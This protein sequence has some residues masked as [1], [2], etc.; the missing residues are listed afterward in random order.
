MPLGATSGKVVGGGEEQGPSPLANIFKL[1][2]SAVGRQAEDYGNIMG[3][4][5]EILN[6]TRNPAE[7]YRPEMYQYN[8]GPDLQKSIGN[9]E[10]LSKTGGYSEEGIRD[11]RA[12]GVS[13]IR[14]IYQNAQRDI[15]RSKSLAGGYSPNYTASKAKLT[16][17]QAEGTAGALQ[18]VNAGI[19]QNVAQNKLAI[20][21]A[22]AGTTQRESETANQYG[23]QNVNRA[24]EG[25]QFNI[26]NSF[27]TLEEAQNAL[28]GMT[29]LYGTTPALS[30]LF[31]SQ[32]MGQA[33]L[34]NNIN[35]QGNQQGLQIIAQMLAG[36]RN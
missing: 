17:E 23:A 27:K 21:P 35:Q 13:P 28:R 16:R 7:R 34:Q 1:Y 36:A 9:L 26:N 24:N 30:S 19:A 12:R 22:Y 25:Q 5:N 2:S 6:K 18:N 11:L 15:A 3:G 20:A 31:G 29:S 8:R 14:A 10:E 33:G 4:Y 32:A